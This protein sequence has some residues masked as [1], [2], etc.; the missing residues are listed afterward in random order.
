MYD[1]YQPRNNNV[2]DGDMLADSRKLLKRWKNYFSSYW[3]YIMSVMLDR[4]R[5][6]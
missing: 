6:S 4:N 1:G 5:Y 2:N 3:I